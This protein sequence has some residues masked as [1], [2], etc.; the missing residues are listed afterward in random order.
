MC[1]IL[2]KI[3]K[4]DDLKSLS[5]A[6]LQTLCLELR[7]EIVKTVS[8]NGGHLS[9]NLGTVELAVALNRVFCGE[10]D[11]VLWDVG[12]QAYVHKLLT[13]RMNQFLSLRKFN[14]LS[15]FLSPE[16]SPY[17]KF[18]TGHAGVVISEAIG[19]AKA[20]AI[21]HKK[22]ASVVAVIGDGSL[23]DVLLFV[24]HFC[25]GQKISF[26]SRGRSRT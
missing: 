26:A 4:P 15:G 3:E 22:D 8:V 2:E 9:P 20:N 25:N 14:G 7:K 23:A 21:N 18:Y 10:D 19:L 13:G 24:D 17:D 11:S 6:E 16:E 1:S 12:H 5:P